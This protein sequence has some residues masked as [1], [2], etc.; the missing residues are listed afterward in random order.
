[1]L[2][3]K[4]ILKKVLVCLGLLSNTCIIFTMFQS[5]FVEIITRTKTETGYKLYFRFSGSS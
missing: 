1:M 4:I 2:H 5:V 3:T